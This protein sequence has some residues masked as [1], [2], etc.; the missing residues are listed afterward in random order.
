VNPLGVVLVVAGCGIAVG[1]L[2]S[3]AVVALVTLQPWVRFRPHYH[4]GVPVENRPAT[5]AAVGQALLQAGIGPGR[6]L[7]DRARGGQVSRHP[8]G[9]RHLLSLVHGR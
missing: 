4:R 8:R 2:A 1:A 5:L 7:T 6:D 9:A 3:L